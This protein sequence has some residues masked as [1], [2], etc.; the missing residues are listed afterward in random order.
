MD[1]KLTEAKGSLPSQ[2]Q[3][4]KDDMLS[5][6]NSTM[7][8]LSQGLM[9][10]KL[11]AALARLQANATCQSCEERHEEVVEASGVELAEAKHEVCIESLRKSVFSTLADGM[12]SGR[13]SQV[14]LSLKTQA[15][16]QARQVEREEADTLTGDDEDCS[17][18]GDAMSIDCP[19]EMSEEDLAIMAITTVGSAARH[20]WSDMQQH[21]EEAMTEL[22]EA[23]ILEEAHSKF[24][25]LE[26]EPAGEKQTTCFEEETSDVGVRSSD[27][28]SC[29]R[30]HMAPVSHTLFAGKFVLPAPAAADE[31]LRTRAVESGPDA[32]IQLPNLASRLARPLPWQSPF[33]VALSHSTGATIV[34]GIARSSPK[35]GKVGILD[36]LEQE[37]L[38]T[39]KLPEKLGKLKG[40]HRVML[41]SPSLC[42]KLPAGA[43]RPRQSIFANANA[44]DASGRVDFHCVADID[45]EPAGK[46]KRKVTS[47]AKLNSLIVPMSP[48]SERSTNQS[49]SCSAIALDLGLGATTWPKPP[50]ANGSRRASLL[51]P[52]SLSKSSSSSMLL[53]VKSK[54]TILPTLAIPY[55]KKSLEG[56]AV[57][58]Q[59]KSF[60][61]WSETAESMIL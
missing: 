24:V 57:P 16:E 50:G 39:P 49:Q 56:W 7:Q 1:G 18:D 58:Q 33:S 3:L 59:H 8:V 12:L 55:S 2:E 30:E 20:A 38:T 51:S 15:A 54:A 6:R 17:D 29:M 37:P 46:S 19:S 28:G 25:Q 4:N 31:K 32:E 9:N 41:S 22:Q 47:V 53:S 23:K 45:A 11:E 61:K 34:G 52:I 36:K 40:I 48:K 14:Y 26:L 5:L 21:V 27:F 42:S 35:S 13:L 10:G 44:F 43:L 60:R